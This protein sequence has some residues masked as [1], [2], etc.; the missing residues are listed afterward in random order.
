MTD[1]FLPP[2]P[3]LFTRPLSALRANP[4]NA[5]THSKRQI[6]LIADSIEAFGF[7]NPILIDETG[8]VLAGHG[9][10]A[11]ARRLKLATAPTL[12]LASLSEA[13]KRAYVLADNRL[14]ER[15]GWD[16]SLL[17][18]ELGELAVL[19]PSLDLDWSIDVA[20]FETGDIEALTHDHA[21][22]PTEPEDVMP[23]G[24][25][26]AIISRLGDMWQLGAHRVLCG[27]AQCGCDV[28]RAMAGTH[29][30]MVFTDPPYNV[31]IAGH[32]KRAGDRAHREFAM[33]SGEMSHAEFKTFLETCLGHA[34]RASRP[35][36]V[37]DVC[38]DWRHIGTLATV[39]ESLYED[40]LNIC[41]WNKG[42][43]G[44]GSFYRSQHEFVAIF[45]VRGATHQNNVKLGR[46]GRNRSNVWSY[47][48]V[49]GY[50]VDRA[51]ALAMHPT[52]KPVALVVDALRDCTLRGEVVFDPF[53]GS[54]T[55]LIAAEKVGR[56][57]RGLE[58]DPA[59]VDTIVR[60]WQA[61]AG[62]DAT[63]EDGGAS[64]DEVEAMR[65]A[66]G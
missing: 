23:A 39:G 51:Q 22:T 52:V 41:V 36:A 59:Y 53:L 26:R 28:E 7:T 24:P 11:A 32:V 12:C 6:K 48:G 38:M 43:A 33:A 50:G 31:A 47:P 65:L 20:G 30:N 14:A 37:H 45:R 19:L 66:A 25:D 44:Q 56:V 4:R 13:Q 63:L 61:Y 17:A 54:G 10:L 3:H 64:F 35:G 9:R 49:N 62:A 18:T 60:R 15:A 58:L 57:C 5:R 55:S 21:E 27:D 40:L 8:M 2:M 46:F 16:R 29:A 1:V 34:V 42:V